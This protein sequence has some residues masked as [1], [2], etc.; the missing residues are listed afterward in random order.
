MHVKSLVAQLFA[1]AALAGCIPERTSFEATKAWTELKR[2]PEMETLV[3]SMMVLL[4]S[5]GL[6]PVVVDPGAQ[7]SC[8]YA[9]AFGQDHIGIDPQCV[10]TLRTDNSYNWKTVATLG[11]EVGHIVA[12]HIDVVT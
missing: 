7:E 6:V 11:H 2:V 1:G 4:G 5:R 12:R 10:G 8:A 3:A 9:T